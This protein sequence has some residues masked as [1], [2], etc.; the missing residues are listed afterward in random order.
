[1]EEKEK[2]KKNKH[3]RNK[4]PYHIFDDHNFADSVS[5]TD[6]TGLI[7]GNP[8]S[9]QTFETYSHIYEFTGAPEDEDIP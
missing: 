7:P 8:D 2:Q 5:A 6:C 9:A 4:N 1:M 3:Y